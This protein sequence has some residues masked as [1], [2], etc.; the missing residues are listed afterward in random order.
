LLCEKLSSIDSRLKEFEKK[1]AS[2]R[3]F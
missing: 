1:D 2:W 3:Q